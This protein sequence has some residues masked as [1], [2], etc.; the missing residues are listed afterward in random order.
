MAVI[1]NWN[2]YRAKLNGMAAGFSLARAQSAECAIEAFVSIP[3]VVSG[4]TPRPSV[5]L[6][7]DLLAPR[8]ESSCLE[9]ER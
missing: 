6:F 3:K 7:T 1:T 8:S 9:S 5:Y 2:L 4:I